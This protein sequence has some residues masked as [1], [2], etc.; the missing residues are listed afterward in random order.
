[1]YIY[2]EKSI[3]AAW[4][5]HTNDAEKTN[6]LRFLEYHRATKPKYNLTSSNK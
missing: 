3:I 6:S 4:Y 1:M 5:E 2:Y